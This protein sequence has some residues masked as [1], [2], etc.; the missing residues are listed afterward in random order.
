MLDLPFER[1]IISHGEP[2]H[3]RDAFE[4]AFELPTWPASSLHMAAWHCDLELV[5][6]LVQGGADL[7]GGC[8]TREPRIPTR[9]LWTRTVGAS[10]LGVGQEAYT[11]RRY[12]LPPN[13]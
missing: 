5:R 1:V 9:P 7:T 8:L 3:T 11:R 10:A 2:V 6:S 4:P 12:R 13:A